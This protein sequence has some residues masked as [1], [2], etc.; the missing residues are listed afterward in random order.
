MVLDK[1]QIPY[2][3]RWL[4]APNLTMFDL[5]WKSSGMVDPKIWA[6]WC[7]LC[8]LV[9]EGFATMTDMITTSQL[10]AW[11]I[12]SHRFWSTC[13]RCNPCW[14][15][16]VFLRQLEGFQ[17]YRRQLGLTHRN[18]TEHRGAVGCFDVLR[19][20]HAVHFLPASSN[21]R[22]SGWGLTTLTRDEPAKVITGSPD[23]HSRFIR[24]LSQWW[25][26]CPYASTMK[27][28]AYKYG[29]LV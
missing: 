15:L 12:L 19:T 4:W 8:I 18:I 5:N 22:E 28:Q 14:L 9:G 16:H 13:Y 1:V 2:V 3:W 21:E 25:W 11:D 6:K 29:V 26:E 17:R 20:S 10:S 24:S 27:F 23:R 7:N